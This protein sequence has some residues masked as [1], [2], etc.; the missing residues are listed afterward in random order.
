MGERLTQSGPAMGVL[1]GRH[2]LIVEDDY[3]IA[4]EMAASLAAHGATILGPAG[5]VADAR[6]LLEADHAPL[7]GAVL[8]INL[9]GERVFPV[10]DLLTASGVPFVFAT[11]YDLWVIPQPYAEVPRCA[12]PV[13]VSDLVQL[14]DGRMAKKARGVAP[15]PD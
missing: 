14:L 13:R 8:D 5:S 12:K 15:G 1:R 4:M 6:A 7:D 2:L 10:A 3:L 11:G 9:S